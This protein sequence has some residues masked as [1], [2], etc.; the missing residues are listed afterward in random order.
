MCIRNMGDETDNA[1][2]APGVLS[3]KATRS[4][5]PRCTNVQFDGIN[6]DEGAAVEVI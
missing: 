5:S 2:A 6:G 3:P 4:A 1:S